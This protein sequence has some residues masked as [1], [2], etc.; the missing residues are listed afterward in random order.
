MSLLEMFGPQ[1][2]LILEQLESEEDK[3]KSAEADFRNFHVFQMLN[4]FRT[5]VIPFCKSL[6]V[7]VTLFRRKSPAR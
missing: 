5:D 4:S 2:S 1:E 7:E 6:F 3:F